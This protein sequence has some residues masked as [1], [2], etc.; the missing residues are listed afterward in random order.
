MQ[1]GFKPTEVPLSTYDACRAEG[2]IIATAHEHS[3]SRTHLMSS[4][5]DQTILSTASEFGIGPGQTFAFVSG[6]GGGSQ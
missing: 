4:F 6:L 2:A 3:Y 1:V 5:A